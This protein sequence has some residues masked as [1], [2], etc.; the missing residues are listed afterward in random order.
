MLSTKK[1]I[2][3][4]VQN[5]S[6]SSKDLKTLT[7]RNNPRV[8]QENMFFELCDLT[9]N[10]KKVFPNDMASLTE[11]EILDKIKDDD[12]YLNELITDIQS[13]YK[14][15]PFER[16]KLIQIYYQ[17]LKSIIVESDYDKYCEYLH[18]ENL[19]LNSLKSD[20]LIIEGA[21]MRKS[22]LNG[23]L[24]EGF[25]EYKNIYDDFNDLNKKY[26]LEENFRDSY[27]ALD[28]HYKNDPTLTHI[29]EDNPT[30]D[31][32]RSAML[33][34]LMLYN[35]MLSSKKNLEITIKD[36]QDFLGRIR[37]MYIQSH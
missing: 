16:D 23:N 34:D 20:N 24:H 12:P 21:E 35:N 22:I 25:E 5:L 29:I 10:Y 9:E 28:S 4:T 27:N 31:I 3:T 36:L 6:M 18:Q 32:V 2:E 33:N 14:A 26:C 1:D 30:L 13:Y 19:I 7:P 11:K 37:N 8:G 15:V 17:A